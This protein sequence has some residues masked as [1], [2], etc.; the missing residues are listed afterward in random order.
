MKLDNTRLAPAL[1]ALARSI[2]LPLVT[3]LTLTLAGCGGGSND[4]PAT[5]TA[6][7]AAGEVPATA[8]DSWQTFLDY[9]RSLGA[10]DTVEPNTLQQKL[11]PVDDT[12][13]PTPLS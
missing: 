9:Q 2:S 10:S 7:A 8:L 11:P 6:P 12:I 1:T 13:E 4:A 3:T 5:A